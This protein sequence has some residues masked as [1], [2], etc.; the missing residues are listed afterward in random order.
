MN[1][2]GLFLWLGALIFVGLTLFKD[3]QLSHLRYF[4]PIGLGA[5]LVPS[6]I[7]FPESDRRVVPLA[8]TFYVPFVTYFWIRSTTQTVV[9]LSLAVPLALM[10]LASVPVF[11]YDSVRK[12][13]PWLVAAGSCGLLIASL[14][15]S[16]GGPDPMRNWYIA[17]LNLTFEQAYE[18]THYTRK[19]IHFACYGLIAFFAAKGRLRADR[20]L[21]LALLF[22]LLWALPH[23]IFDEWRQS[24]ELSRTGSGWDVALDSAGMLFMLT[25][26]AWRHKK[27]LKSQGI[28]LP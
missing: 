9:P 14:S 6:L 24:F 11:G 7:L 17:H 16:G 4:L 22:G 5:M 12:A 26:V 3:W 28:Q 23:A 27:T 19:V 13:L 18:L 25:L 15:G 1:R 21:K 8:L 2:I 20:E 10:S